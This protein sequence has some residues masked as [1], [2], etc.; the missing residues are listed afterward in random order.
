MSSIIQTCSSGV[1]EICFVKALLNDT[2]FVFSEIIIPVSRSP[3]FNFNAI[4]S[5]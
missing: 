3:F 2:W 1:I 4:V 5:E